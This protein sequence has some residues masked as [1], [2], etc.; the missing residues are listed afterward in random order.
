MPTVTPLRAILLLLLAAIGGLVLASA[1][2]Q[3]AEEPHVTDP[4]GDARETSPETALGRAQRSCTAAQPVTHEA[5]SEAAGAGLWPP[6]GAAGEAG[7]TGL[8]PAPPSLDVVAGWFEETPT[9]LRVVLQVAELDEAL[10]GLAWEE[11]GAGGRSG[12]LGVGWR[13]GPDGACGETLWFSA[14]DAALEHVGPVCGIEDPAEHPWGGGC[15]AWWWCTY[16]IETE[17]H[18]GTPGTVV[19]TVPRELLYHGEAGES[20][21]EVTLLSWRSQGARG[22]AMYATDILGTRAWGDVS[23]G[24]GYV[25][26]RSEPGRPFV[27]QLAAETPAGPPGTPHYV[28]DRQTASDPRLEILSVDVVETPETLGYELTLADVEVDA[29]TMFVWGDR[30]SVV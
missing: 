1:S 7:T 29:G 24:H 2:A 30:K 25:T 27:F 17:V 5:C 11:D 16:E 13:A 28:A 22:G 9:D 6:E 15:N 4:E 23:A 26:D 21:Q 3:T 18:P 19:W 12:A 14:E 20:L 8:I 10:T